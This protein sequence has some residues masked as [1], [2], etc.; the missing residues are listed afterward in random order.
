MDNKAI[1]QKKKTNLV[2]ED[3]TN[4]KFEV[5]R[6]VFTNETILDEEMEK[7]FSTCWLYIGHESELPNKGDFRRRKVGGRNLIFTRSK[8]GEIRALY[9]TCPHRG[10]MVCRESKGNAKVFQCFYHAWT[11][12]NKGELVGLP[13][14]ESFPDTFNCDGSKN[15]LQVKRLD[16]Y[17]GFVFINF[18]DEAE[19]LEEYLG[20]AKTYIDLVADQSEEGMK[21][22]GDPQEYS[23]RANWK[24][25]SENSMD[26][27]HGLPTHK[28]YFEIVATRGGELSK[29]N[30]TG[31]GLDLGNGHGV[32]E[33]TA[34]WGRPVAKWMP[35]WGEDGRKEIEKTYK[36]LVEKYGEERA[37]RI[38]NNS[39]N[40]TIFPNLVIN[41][42][43]GI[44]V[45]TFNP[46]SPG[47]ME[48][49]GYALAPVEESKDFNVRRMDN[50]LEFLGPGGFAT[51]DDNE[52]LELCQEGYENN[53]E[54]EWND[55]S[56]GM[57]KEQPASGDEEQMRGFWRQWNR[58][59]TK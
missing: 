57:T 35:A 17:R 45:R 53:Y 59:M 32:V 24:L 31:V 21:I 5:H 11:F 2:V 23:M 39:R 14:K 46:I 4:E 8:D 12:S 13:D 1:A 55:I 51:P 7:I 34:P 33:Y 52:A 28:T 27:Y 15:L 9:N 20:N 22:I 10:A 48:V 56:K 47:Y 54:V 38:S 41:D 29:D 37:H 50:F 6:S 44:T 58:L 30:F 36:R 40:M 16:S 26:S 25:L 43:M 42:I 18:N 19:P 3:H 49:S